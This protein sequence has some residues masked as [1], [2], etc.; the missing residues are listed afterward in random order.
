M[1]NEISPRTFRFGEVVLKENRNLKRIIG[2][3]DY[4]FDKRAKLLHIGYID[5]VNTLCKL[6]PTEHEP[7]SFK[8]DNCYF[9]NNMINFSLSGVFKEGKP[10]DNVRPLRSFHRTFVCIPD[11]NSQMTIV[12]EQFTIS[13]VSH[14]QYKKY[15]APKPK[16]EEKQTFDA[17]TL[18][19]P[20][21]VVT[22][23][24][25]QNTIILP[26]ELVGLNEQQCLMIQQF[27]VE[28]RLNLE[29]SKHCLDHSQWIYEDAAKAFLQ[30]K[31]SIPKEA[32]L[33]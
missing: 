15:F 28:S 13:S 33:A 3:D 4:H 26:P 10:T 31:E 16:I 22:S 1:N 24:M 20:V 30:F 29:W 32:Y 19:A 5:A 11:P 23:I 6:P 7:S 18:A 27:S 8:L 2:N 9:S 25:P 12:N 21:Q 17:A 14:G